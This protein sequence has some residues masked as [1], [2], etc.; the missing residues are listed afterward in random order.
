MPLELFD[1]WWV[2]V[3]QK[4]KLLLCFTLAQVAKVTLARMLVEWKIIYFQQKLGAI[5]QRFVRPK[6]F[7]KELEL[8]IREI[9]FS[10]LH[11][12]TFCL[13][14]KFGFP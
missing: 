7:K 6:L 2:L 9:V 11:E 14:D 5:I 8:N 4:G 3:V 1:D 12:M 10:N 13:F